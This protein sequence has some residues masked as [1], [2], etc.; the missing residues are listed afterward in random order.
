MNNKLDL[1]FSWKSI[2]AR[3][4][5]D[6]PV[7]EKQHRERGEKFKILMEKADSISDEECYRQIEE[8]QKLLEEKKAMISKDSIC[9][10]NDKY[11]A[12]MNQEDLE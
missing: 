3:F 11:V 9:I 5:A 8:H 7:S 12:D 1:D 4:D 2:K 10:S 6:N